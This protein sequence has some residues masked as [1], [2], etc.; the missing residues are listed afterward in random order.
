MKQKI[1]ILL[2]AMLLSSVGVFA[3]SG[4]SEP[5]KGDVNGDGKVDM[6][7]VTELIDI[8][9]GR[10]GTGPVNPPEETY[11]WYVGQ[12][13]P[14]TMDSISPIVDDNDMSS[15]GWRKIEDELS[16][17]GP[18]KKIWSGNNVITTGASFAKQYIVIPHESA[19]CPRDGAGSDASTVGIYNKLSNITISGVE[20]KVY[21]TVGNKKK[22]D[23]D[24]Y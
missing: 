8:I 21:E 3:Q 9:L 23:L 17:Y 13:D 2:A 11:Y 1:L 4:N 15:P 16:T 22:H 10:S 20:Y 12:T 5:L 14:S 24:I 6:A 7:D 18:S 19:A